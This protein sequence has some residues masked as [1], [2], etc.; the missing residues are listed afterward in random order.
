MITACRP[1]CQRK[2]HV[3][4][5][6]FGEFDLRRRYPGRCSAMITCMRAQTNLTRLAAAIAVALSA[7]V[8]AAT[9][10]AATATATAAPAKTATRWRAAEVRSPSGGSY[11][12]LAAVT[13]TGAHSCVA[14][15]SY[16]SAASRNALAM[17]GADS[18]GKWAVQRSI[19]L[20]A[21]ALRTLQSATVASIACP[22]STACVAVGSDNTAAGLGGFIATGHGNTWGRAISPAWPKGTAVPAVG[23]L[24]GV[25]CTG[26]GTC[27]AVG[28]YDARG[29]R[30][31]PL[32]VIESGGHW[33]RAT[34]IRAP[35]NAGANPV[36][37]LTA[38]SCPKAGD[39][40]AVGT[41]MTKSSQGEAMAVAQG[42]RGW[43]QATEIQL[44][45]VKVEPF[46]ELFSISCVKPGTCEAV[47]TYAT[48]SNVNLALAVG[49]SGGHWRRG[50]NLSALPLGAAGGSGANSVLNGVT[51]TAITS[52]LAVGEYTDK[53]G[54]L[55]GMLFIDARGKWGRAAEVGPPA[56][57][58]A[59]SAQ[60]EYLFGI[61]CRGGA[62]TAVG[63]YVSKSHVG[64]AMAATGGT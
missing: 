45:P 1:L 56:G 5:W 29:S 51:C 6:R 39:C 28:G 32:V 52:C 38:V 36:A 53:Q 47:G 46:A 58:A 24:T 2:D 50:V 35:S 3:A 11:G 23:Y 55:L 25:S 7:L 49:E 16:Y 43:G 48:P 9:A 34:A 17:I 19:R 20:P 30:Q 4:L 14:G 22:A 62:C 42:K 13:C 57:S 40:V 18:R 31:E 60:Q 37:H 44:P 63:N 61:A 33:R 15:G 59:G 41:Y 12:N 64:Q 10:T 27:V 21:N 26:R 8:P 54:G